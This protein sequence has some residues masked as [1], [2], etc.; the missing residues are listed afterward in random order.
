MT[1]VRISP[2]MRARAAVPDMIV[3]AVVR[4]RLWAKRR[5]T[6]PLER[7]RVEMEHLLGAVAP[8]RVDPAATAYVVRD[9]MRSEM[10]YH[11]RLVTR[12]DVE[13][14]E[15][16]T[17]ARSTGR[18]V[19]VSFLHHGHY[20]GTTAALAL[21][22]A[23][24]GIVVSPEML[25]PEAPAFL[26]QHLR[27]GT[28]TGNWTVDAGLGGREL[29]GRLARGEALAIA[30]DVPGTSVV[31]FLG[32]DRRGSSGAARLAAAT[33]SLV[34]TMHAHCGSDGKQ[35]VSLGNP[36]EPRDFADA[37]ALLRHLVSTQEAPVLAWPEAYHQPSLRWGEPATTEA[38]GAPETAAGG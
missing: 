31:P 21:A 38:S 24:L 13:N 10:R 30:T 11:P 23:P 27:T 4:G 8:E 2:S 12:Q 22:D 6:G 9:V 18:G 34:V 35:W 14:A 17:R 36:I 26:R 29:A 19:V 16:L 5:R 37:D 3:P 20:E 33:N 7:A 1:E 28:S 32:R 25:A 15:A